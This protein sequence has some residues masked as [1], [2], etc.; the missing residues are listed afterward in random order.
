MERERCNNCNGEEY[1]KNGFR[2]K[3]QTLGLEHVYYILD[4]KARVL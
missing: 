1:G 2:E 3:K 4:F